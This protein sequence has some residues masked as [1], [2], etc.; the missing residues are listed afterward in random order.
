MQATLRILLA[1]V[2][3]FAG[4]GAYA[5]ESKPY[6]RDFLASDAVRLAETL[7]KETAGEAAL[8]KGKN[9]EQLRKEAAAAADNAD[10]KLAGKLAAAAVT[11]NA[12]D[13]ANWLQLS[14]VAVKADDAQAPERYDL[15]ERGTTAAYAAYLR[16]TA[17]APQASAFAMSPLVSMPPAAMTWT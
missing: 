2:S 6:A 3:I 10:Y 14:R 4:A 12:K 17:S 13:A 7:R 9:P 16:L 11:G 5:A 8:T 1:L 15:R